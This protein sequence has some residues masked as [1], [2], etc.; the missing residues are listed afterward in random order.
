MS[1]KGGKVLNNVTVVLSGVV[2]RCSG[3]WG[4]RK[5]ANSRFKGISDRSRY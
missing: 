4:P 3:G 1:E 5:L 2:Y